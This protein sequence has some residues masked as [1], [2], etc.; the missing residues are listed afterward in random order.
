MLSDKEHPWSH[1]NEW[2]EA[3]NQKPVHKDAGDMKSWVFPG[4]HEG[5]NQIL[6]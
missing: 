1:E 5:L 6:T 2:D 4:F 3:L